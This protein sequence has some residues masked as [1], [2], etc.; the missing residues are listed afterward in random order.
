MNLK[1]ETLGLLLPGSHNLKSG[2]RLYC[3][4]KI[5]FIK[6]SIQEI[7]RRPSVI[8]LTFLILVNFGIT[9]SSAQKNSQKRITSLQFGELAE[10]SRVSVFSDSALTDYEAFRRGDRFYVRIPLADFTTSQPNFRGDGFDDVQVQRS[11]DSILISFKLQLGANARVDQRSNRLDVIFSAP[12]K[13]VRRST[14]NPAPSRTTS[15]AMPGIVVLQNSR[16]QHQR[17]PDAA[18]PMPPDSPNSNRPRLV[19]QEFSS[20]RSVTA[21]SPA[22]PSMSSPVQTSSH[23]G[24]VNKVHNKTAIEPSPAKPVAS[25][26]SANEVKPASKSDSPSTFTPSPTPGYPTVTAVAQSTPWPS[27]TIANSPSATSSTGWRKRSELAVQWVSANRVVASV[28]AFV[29]LSLVVFSVSMIYLKRRKHVNTK[30][31][32]VPGV[33]PKNSPAR[34]PEDVVAN[35]NAEY[36]DMLFDEYLSDVNDPEVTLPSAALDFSQP[37]NCGLEWAEEVSEPTE[38][39]AAAVNQRWMPATPPISSYTTRNEVPEREVFEL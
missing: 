31:L 39:P 11:G 13:V 16:N 25:L 3:P 29:V 5:N 18:G 7:R 8:V 26:S 37:N 12:N 2:C 4:M 15:K 28:G 33:Q 27:R 10:G 6:K 22:Q 9:S 32:K 24:S 14:A 17:N 19:T 36:D 23:R 30:R 34:D 1:F 35:S 20:T 21:S 38:P